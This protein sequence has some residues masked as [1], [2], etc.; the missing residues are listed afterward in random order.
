M[1]TERA[2][3]RRVGTLEGVGWRAPRRSARVEGSPGRPRLSIVPV[4]L[5]L[6][7]WERGGARAEDGRRHRSLTDDGRTNG[8]R[9]VE[10][11]CRHKTRLGE[12]MARPPASTKLVPPFPSGLL[13]CSRHRL[14]QLRALSRCRRRK[15]SQPVGRSRRSSSPNQ[16]A[17]HRRARSRAFWLGGGGVVGGSGVRWVPLGGGKN[18]PR[19][20]L[21]C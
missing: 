2:R 21:V 11:S 6:S 5:G 8:A 14:M 17:L 9:L 13:P 18:I 10:V 15:K 20:R 3:V 19:E 1:P 7:Q 16:R 4:S 12:S